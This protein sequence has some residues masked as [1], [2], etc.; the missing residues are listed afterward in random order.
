M[1]SSAAAF[2]AALLAAF[3]LIPFVRGAA[4][5][6]GLLDEP[7]G[8][9]VHAVAIPRLGGV[10]ITVAFYLGISV[11]LIVARAGGQTLDLLRGHV[12][13]VLVGAALMAGVG[14]VDDVE[15]MRARIKLAAQVVVALVAYGLGLSVDRLDGPWGSLDL[16]LWSLPVTVAWFVAV[17]NALNLIDGLDGL[18]SG[19]ALTALAAFFVI[20]WADPNAAPILPVLAAVAGG[21]I[22]FLRYNLYPASIIMGDTGSMLIGFLLAAVGVNLTQ[23][24][25]AGDGVVPWVPV[26]ALALP[27]ADMLW[28]IVRRLIAGAPIF[29]PDKRHIHHQLVARGLS[30]RSAMLALTGVS[31]LLAVAAVLLAR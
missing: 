25:P 2:V 23:A 17:I 26:V 7:G 9:K 6:A 11:A 14:V 30:Q 29:A 13:G 8:R 4:R 21:A 19:V 10:A 31:A 18:A 12:P 3:V 16:G 15:G 22:G 27:L 20:G 5:E 1:L 24:G 28:A